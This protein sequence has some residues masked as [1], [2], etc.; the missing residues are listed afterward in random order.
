MPI[1]KL[2]YKTLNDDYFVSIANMLLNECYL[3]INETNYRLVEIEFYLKCTG[4]N[5]PYTHCD[6]DQL[7]MH[8]FYFHKFKTGTYK[9]GTFKG[10]DL[11]FGDAKTKSYFGILIRSIENM[12][13]NDIT[14]GPCNVVNQI[15]TEYKQPSIMDFTLGQNL[16]IFDNDNNF[17]LITDDDLPQKELFYGP[18]IGLSAK[19]P[20][21]QNKPYR[22][23]ADKLAIKKKRATLI[24]VPFE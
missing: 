13:S 14:E 24:N 2:N 6:P 4:H 8:S 9:A 10:L 11:T 22:F 20:E 17:I 18:R 7:L 19:Y 21:Y 12:I 3:Q 15:L 1:T 5:D 16:N 23:V